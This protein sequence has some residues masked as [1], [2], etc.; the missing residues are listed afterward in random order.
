MFKYPEDGIVCFMYGGAQPV[1]ILIHPEIV[2][3]LPEEK[4]HQKEQNE[5]SD[6]NAD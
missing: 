6:D 1:V 4:V 5:K 2:H 3:D